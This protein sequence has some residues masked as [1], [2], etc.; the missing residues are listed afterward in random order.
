MNAKERVEDAARR[1]DTDILDV[2]FSAY[3]SKYGGMSDISNDVIL[4]E[5]LG[6]VPEYVTEF[7]E[8]QNASH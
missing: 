6:I 8:A 7:L 4:F 1:L 3:E 2:F 5:F